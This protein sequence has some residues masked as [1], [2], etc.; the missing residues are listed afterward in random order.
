VEY[1]H[2]MCTLTRSGLNS[3]SVASWSC[4]G[5]ATA[6]AGGGVRERLPLLL[7]WLGTGPLLLWLL[8]PVP[9][10]NGPAANTQAGKNYTPKPRTTR[11]PA[12]ADTHPGTVAASAT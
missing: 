5:T 11:Q 12:T 1:W 6:L 10:K 4:K 7:F 2:F 9:W 3:A 8:L